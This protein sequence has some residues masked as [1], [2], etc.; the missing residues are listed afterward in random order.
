MSRKFTV[1]GKDIAKY[2]VSA[3]LIRTFMKG[4]ELPGD[5]PENARKAP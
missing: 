1:S 2:F 3:D 5:N 4:V